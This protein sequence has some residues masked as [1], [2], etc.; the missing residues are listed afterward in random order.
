MLGNCGCDVESTPIY[1]GPEP[2]IVTGQNGVNGN[3]GWTPVYAIAVDGLR[4]VLKLADYISGIGIKPTANINSYVSSSG[5][6]TDITLAENIAGPAGVGTTGSA[7]WTPELIL[8]IDGARRVL[9]INSWNGGTGT[10]P[11][12]GYLGI[13]GTIVPDVASG[14]DIRGAAGNPGADSTVPGPVSTVPGPPGPT[15]VVQMKTTNIGSEGVFSNGQHYMFLE[16]TSFAAFTYHK[17]FV[18]A[19]ASAHTV[20]LLTLQ[21]RTGDTTDVNLAT[22]VV[23]RNF[24][25]PTAATVETIITFNFSLYTNKRYL[26]FVIDP[27]N[28]NVPLS[29]PSGLTFIQVD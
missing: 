24:Y 8:V 20:G 29:G 10:P 5:F 23:H 15:G 16:N 22:T 28:T 6:T 11:P 21:L 2:V 1:F 4:R 26:F 19:Y 18:S 13:S 27:L 3:N 7:G 25:V 17:F 9:R 14:V 12:V